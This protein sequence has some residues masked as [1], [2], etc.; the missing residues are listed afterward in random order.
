MDRVGAG[1]GPTGGSQLLLQRSDVLMIGWL[2]TAADAGVYVV[3]CNV[4][5]LGAFPF[6]AVSSIVAPSFAVHYARGERR[7]S[8]PS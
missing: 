1:P 3:A 2:M 6:L 5:E 8:P 4:A 7:N